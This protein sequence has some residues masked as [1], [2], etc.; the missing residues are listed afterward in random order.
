MFSLQLLPPG[1]VRFLKG[2]CGTSLYEFALV[3]SLFA[4]IGVI[5]MI[6]LAVT[7]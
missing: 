6:A 7:A 5:I 4:L 2:Q 3:L 1:V